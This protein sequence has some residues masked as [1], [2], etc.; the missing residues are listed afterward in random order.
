MKVC[1]LKMKDGTLHKGE[2]Q[3][4]LHMM[5]E[6]ELDPDEIADCGWETVPGEI[7]WGC[8]DSIKNREEQD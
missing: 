8:G 4:H 6:L 2:H 7:N 3:C 5:L 1:V